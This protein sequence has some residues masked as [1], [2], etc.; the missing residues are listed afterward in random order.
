MFEGTI[1]WA[2]V[3]LIGL[4][5]FPLA[6][7]ILRNLPDRGFSLTKI[8]GLLLITYVLWLGGTLHVIPNR[9]ESIVAILCLM[10]AVS[11]VLAWRNRSELGSFIRHRWAHLL[12]TEFLF[13]AVFLLSL[14]LRSLPTDSLTGP[15]DNRWQIAFVNSILR[16]DYF[17]P[18]DPWLSGHSVSYYYFGFVIVSM[19]IKLTGIA[20]EIAFNLTIALVAALAVSGMFG[21][22]Y[23]FLIDRGKQV[24]VLICGVLAGVFL[25]FLS[26]I[27]AVFELM[28]VHGVGSQ[29]FYEYI[30]VYGLGV[31]RT[32]NEWFPTDGAWTYRSINFSGHRFDSVFPFF[33]MLLPIGYLSARN[34]AVPILVLL[35]AVLV[36]VWRSGPF[37]LHLMTRADVVGFGFISLVLG[38][39][40]AAH[41]WDFPTASA[42]ILLTLLFRNYWVDRR[43]SLGAVT[44]TAL[45]WAAITVSA[46]LLYLPSFLHATSQ[47]GGVLILPADVATKPH[48]LLY[49][50]LP[51]FWLTACLLLVSLRNFRFDRP[52]LWA[53]LLPP[54]FLV[55]SWAAYRV[56]DGSVSQ[57]WNDVDERGDAW[58]SVAILATLISVTG[59]ALLRQLLAV[60]MESREPPLVFA[61][62]SATIALLLIMGVEFFFVDEPT[63]RGG[64]ETLDFATVLRVN[65]Q[66]WL[67]LSLAGALGIYYIGT[68]WFSAGRLLQPSKA[69]W[70]GGTLAVVCAGLLFPVMTA[71]WNKDIDKDLGRKRSLD[72]FTLARTLQPD[73][74]A[75]IQYLND[76]VPG[77]PVVLE[78][79]T[80]SYQDGGRISAFTGL[81]TL[82]GWVTQEYYFRG[83]YEPWTH[84]REDAAL[85][86]ETPYPT[87]AAA[88]L[89]QYH[90][91]YVVVGRLE[92]EMYGKTGPSKF[93]RFMDTVFKKDEVTVYK[94]RPGA[95]QNDVPPQLLPP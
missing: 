69:A 78:A 74:Y 63:A 49:L 76:N 86:Y 53:A 12:F 1:W 43:F 58:I 91:E 44:R 54:V 5:A 64:H 33:D 47:F 23:N 83:S 65:F 17:P 8:I 37:K 40:I 2:A 16:S 14:F 6:F 52:I 57:L 19:L 20:T 27:E 30:D 60:P 94:T 46:V 41:S 85:I 88:V 4:A 82:L 68:G 36:N 45:F 72:G 31:V 21:I 81:P 87:V 79:V 34:I 80:D 38:A 7:T 25:I 3:E 15:N 84:R 61:L 28:A 66:G 75:A 62:A 77:A 51:L 50:W 56:I 18:E 92:T 26:N 32:S 29:R 13:T 71:F 95:V 22:V 67:L 55:L 24:W 42:L 89:A 48:H 9:R 93:S 10:A 70:V 11:T 90:V 35:I 73:E 59:L 39:L